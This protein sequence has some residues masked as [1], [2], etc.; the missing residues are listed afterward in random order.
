M[1]LC[2]LR[3]S[4]WFQP[5]AFGNPPG[6]KKMV[7]MHGNPKNHFIIPGKILSRDS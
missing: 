1:L 4:H 2:E 5:E 6:R 7:T 3:G